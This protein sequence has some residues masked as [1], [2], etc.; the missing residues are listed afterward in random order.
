MSF[1]FSR[2]NSKLTKNNMNALMTMEEIASANPALTSAKIRVD[3][4]KKQAS[5]IDV[6]CLVTGKSVKRASESILNLSDELTEKIG[7]LRINGK[8][9]LTPVCDAETMVEIIWEL[10]GRA[11]KA[12]RRQ[13][14]HYICRI[15][16]GDESLVEEMK[17]RASASSPAQR[18]FFL[19]KR[20]SEARESDEEAR[21]RKRRFEVEMQERE[22]NTKLKIM[23]ANQMSVVTSKQAIDLY[24]HVVDVTDDVHIQ[25]AF[26]DFMMYNV[27]PSSSSSTALSEYAPDISTIIASLGFRGQTNSTLTKIGQQL[28]RMY[29]AEY[30]EAPQK[31][32]KYVNG[33]TRKVNAYKKV[34]LPMI[35]RVIRSVLEVDHD[36]DEA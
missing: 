15:L 2:H 28:R 9:K 18:D 14:A 3:E 10:P 4:D 19:G 12:F 20:G 5:V 27:S 33:C 35:E 29:M 11:A 16:G 31:T 22:A 24:E 17:D 8:G 26:K 30:G 1:N 7:Q 25:A 32:D 36:E 13:C 6:V 23:E 34:H 21:R